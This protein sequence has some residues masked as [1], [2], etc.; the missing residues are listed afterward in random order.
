[1]KVRLG[2]TGSAHEDSERWY[3]VPEKSVGSPFLS[4]DDTGDVCLEMKDGE[5]KKSARDTSVHRM[6]AWETSWKNPHGES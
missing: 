6:H 4:L 3:Q 2:V 1:M 5:G